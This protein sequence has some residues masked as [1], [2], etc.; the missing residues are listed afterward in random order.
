MLL[1]ILIALYNS[2]YEDI[3]ENADDEYLALFSQKTMQ[4]IRAPDE[5][6]YIAPFNLVEIIV[7][8]LCEWWMPRDKY[9]F[10]NDCVMAT[11]YSPLLFI[12]AIFE[13]RAA[14]TI[15]S[16]RARGEEDD[17]VIEEW[18][19][20]ADEF[21]FESE[22]WAKT[23]ESVKPN[24]DDDPAVLEVMKLRKEV[25]ELKAILGE[26]SKAV[27][28]QARTGDGNGKS[29]D[30]KDDDNNGGSSSSATE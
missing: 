11:L 26:I 12:A 16:N 28:A 17:D 18:E 1:N 9:E 21:D 25:D 8:V 13:T 2:A 4:F 10:V 20:M 6:V 29:K 27:G 24:M 14:A 23:C 30:S 19:E 5:N 15:R 3:Y 7:C 22:G